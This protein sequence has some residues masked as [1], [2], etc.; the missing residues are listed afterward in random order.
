M[1]ELMMRD[2]CSTTSRWQL[3]VTVSAAALTSSLWSYDVEAADD[4]DRP[5][6]WIE[7]GG[8]LERVDTTQTLFAPSFF[9]AT[10]SV[11]Q[12]PMLDSQQRPAYG[13]GGE[14]KIMFAPESSDWVFTAVVRYGRSNGSRHLHH[15]SPAQIPSANAANV[16]SRL[17][18]GDGQ[19]RFNESHY[20]LDFKADRDVGLGIFGSG[21]S[22]VVSV[23]VRYAQF[24]SS[25]NVTL[26]ARPY[27]HPTHNAKYPAKYNRHFSN[28]TAVLQASR[29]T[30]AIGPSLSWD[31]SVPLVRPDERATLDLDWGLNAAVLFGRQKSQIHHQTSRYR[32]DFV[33]FGSPPYPQMSRSVQVHDPNRSRSVTIPNVGGFAGVSLKFPNAKVA[34]GYRA[35]FF[36]GALDD[37]IDEAKKTN[38]GFYGPFATI[39]VGLGG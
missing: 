12:A 19:T 8:Q 36:F 2:N 16:S 20:V 1:S 35:D 9:G 37:G 3:L 6:V 26:H 33:W 21:S 5:T 17:F 28:Y 30:H 39:S 23:G 11:L 15:E 13:F 4:S 32:Y 29:S 31:A 10:R 7:L 25:S 24:N 34:L 18:F 38:V 22:S 14:G 27:D